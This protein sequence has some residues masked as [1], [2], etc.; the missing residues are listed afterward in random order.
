MGRYTYI[1]LSK[2]LQDKNIAC[3]GTLNSNRKEKKKKIKETKGRKEN[4]I[5]C[6][7]DKGEVTL[8]L[9]VVNTKS[10]GIRNVLLLQTINPVHY[11]TQDD[12]KAS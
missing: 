4:W 9:H 8:N 11:V 12:K 10:S 6:K 5:S 7:S 2:W 1:P 3:I